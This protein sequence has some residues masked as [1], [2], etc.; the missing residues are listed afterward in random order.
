LSSEDAELRFVICLT[1]GGRFL[2]DR[3]LLLIAGRLW[4]GP[5]PG[6][7]LQRRDFTVVVGK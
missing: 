5:L 1:K 7:C 3:L 2:S 4:Y 6:E